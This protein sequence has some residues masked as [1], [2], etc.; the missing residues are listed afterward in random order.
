MEPS[1]K[2]YDHEF[3]RLNNLPLP[4]REFAPHY[5]DMWFKFQPKL[6][7]RYEEF[8]QYVQW[9]KELGYGPVNYKQEIAAPLIKQYLF[10]QGVEL[11]TD[12]SEHVFRKKD[13]RNSCHG[14][15]LLSLDIVSANYSVLRNLSASQ[16]LK[17]HDSWSDMCHALGIHEVLGASKSF[18]QYVFGNFNPKIWAKLQKVAIAQLLN[19]IPIDEDDLIFIS[20]DEVVVRVDIPTS[21]F[22]M[23]VCKRMLDD[24]GIAVKGTW[25]TTNGLHDRYVH[26]L[27]TEGHVRTEFDWRDGELQATKKKLVGVSINN[28]Y[29]YFRN[30]MLNEELEEKDLIFMVEKVMAKWI[31]QDEHQTQKF[32]IGSA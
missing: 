10:D 3:F 2:P 12:H 26:G 5:L 18:R 21:A 17:M 14:T 8:L 24:T 23:D 28:F 20:H 6:Q 15:V 1:A 19:L 9:C 25:Y 7:S 31:L 11:K 29:A 16:G 4:V 32:S 13:A 22:V 27:R 30:V